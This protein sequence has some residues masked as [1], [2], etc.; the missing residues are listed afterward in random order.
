LVKKSLLRSLIVADVYHEQARL[1]FRLFNHPLNALSPGIESGLAFCLKEHPMVAHVALETACAV[2]STSEKLAATVE[3]CLESYFC[4]S[5]DWADVLSAFS[6]PELEPE[7]FFDAAVRDQ[8]VLTL[9]ACCCK[10]REAGRY[11]S[12]WLLRVRITPAM[13]WKMPLLW[14]VALVSVPGVQE[15]LMRVWQ[16]LSR[17]TT[18]NA[19]V[20]LLGFG[21][22]SAF[23]VEFRLF[24]RLFK[25]FV[26]PDTKDLKS[27]AQTKAGTL[28]EVV[29]WLEKHQPLS[30][31][32]EL[33]QLAGPVLFPQTKVWSFSI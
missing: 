24:C 3:Q 21:E 13:S 12:Q 26:A 5:S 19:V 31:A 6:P 20:S 28:D 2:I 10:S 27:I 15:S 8:C 18:S 33:L 32:M 14:A 11:V 9:A 30:K 1:L 25:N 7:E 29:S 22:K 23:L 16:D 17:E 4:W